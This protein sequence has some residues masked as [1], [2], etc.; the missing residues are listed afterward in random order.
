MDENVRQRKLRRLLRIKFAD[1]KVLCYK[2]ATMMFVKEGAL[3]F[4]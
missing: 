2:N 3:D 1:W 4:K